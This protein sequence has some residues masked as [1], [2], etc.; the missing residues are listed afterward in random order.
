MGDCREQTLQIFR[1]LDKILEAVG[2][3]RSDI[4]KVTTYLTETSDFKALA[5]ERSKY[6]GDHSPASTLVIIKA[7]AFPELLVEIEAIAALE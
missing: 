5:E 3:E 7:L 4:I 2:A 1:N 6:F